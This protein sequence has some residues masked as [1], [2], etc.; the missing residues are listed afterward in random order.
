M[1]TTPAKPLTRRFSRLY[2][3]L[4]REWRM[5]F[6]RGPDLTELRIGPIDVHAWYAVTFPES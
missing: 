2:V 4:R 6:Y 1:S 3:G 5:S